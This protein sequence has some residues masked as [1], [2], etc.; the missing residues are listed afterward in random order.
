MN[1]IIVARISHREYL[2]SKDHIPSE[3]C[4]SSYDNN[5][6]SSHLQSDAL[7]EDAEFFYLWEWED[8][9]RENNKRYEDVYPEEYHIY[10]D[11]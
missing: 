9:N 10:H 1:K 4:N 2:S 6:E 5:T 11:L 3:Y 8:E 7:F